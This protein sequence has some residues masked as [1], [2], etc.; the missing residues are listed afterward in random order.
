MRPPRL[1][2]AALVA[3]ALGASLLAWRHEPPPRQALAVANPR[4]IVTASPALCECLYAIGAGDRVKGVSRFCLHPDAV[5]AL[6]EI[7][8]FLDPNLQAILELR[9]DALLLQGSPE[10]NGA[11]LAF[12]ADRGIPVELFTI[13]TTKDVLATLTRLGEITDHREQAKAERARLE[14]A[15]AAA[16]G[17]A[18]A[19]RPRILLSI[20]REPGELREVGCAGRESFVVEC[21]EAAG[22]ETLF[23]D[24]ERGY[25]AV[26]KEAVF[27]R[28]PDAIVELR[29]E[30][31][32]PELETVL[33]ADWA[34]AFPD[35]ACVREG[36]VA[37]VFHEAALIPGPRLD[38]VVAKLAAAIERATR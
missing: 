21:L 16:R 3:L 32:S 11:V 12:A 25:R 5:R 29:T 6:P 13:E 23:P 15:L 17:H 28:K 2:A 31:F 4:R 33:R 34:R 24:F 7:G 36:R 19:T 38:E 18:R 27:E 35:L 37:I 30:P 14:G 8:G 9:P 1:L 20:E 22:G 10:T 26:S